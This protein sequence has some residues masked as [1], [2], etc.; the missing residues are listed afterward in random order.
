M[1]FAYVGESCED[2]SHGASVGDEYGRIVAGI[3]DKDE[4]LFPNLLLFPSW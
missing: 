1:G 4:T 2:A 3:D